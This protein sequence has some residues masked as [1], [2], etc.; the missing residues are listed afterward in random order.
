[1]PGSSWSYFVLTLGFRISLSKLR[2]SKYFVITGVKT[3]M[4]PIA[5]ATSTGSVIQV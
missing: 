3:D 4:S 1:M 2:V 5:A